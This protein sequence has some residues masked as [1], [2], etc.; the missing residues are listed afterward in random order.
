L[1]IVNKARFSELVMSA[2]QMSSEATAKRNLK[3]QPDYNRS[4]RN[5]ASSLQ[6][7]KPFIDAAV[8]AH[9]SDLTESRVRQQPELQ[10]GARCAQRHAHNQWS[11]LFDFLNGDQRSFLKQL[12]GVFAVTSGFSF[13][14]QV[15]PPS[16]LQIGI[17]NICLHW[18]S[19]TTKLSNHGFSLFGTEKE[20]E[21]QDW[22]SFL[23]ARSKELVK[24]GVIVANFLSSQD[25]AASI[26]DEIY[27]SVEALRSRGVIESEEL[28]NFN[29]PIC[30][31]SVEDVSEPSQ[32][33]RLGLEL[34]R[35]EALPQSRST[36]YEDFLQHGDLDRF[37]SE[38]STFSDAL[39]AARSEADKAAVCAELWVEHRARVARQ[40]RLFEFT[41]ELRSCRSLRQRVSPQQLQA[42][43]LVLRRLLQI[44]TVR[45]HI[46]MLKFAS[47]SE[48]MTPRLSRTLAACSLDLA[49]RKLP[50]SLAA[51]LPERLL[52]LL[53][54]ERIKALCRCSGTL[55]APTSSD[56]MWTPASRAVESAVLQ[57]K[58]AITKGPAIRSGSEVWGRPQ[59]RQCKGF[60]RCSGAGL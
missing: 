18:C 26:F 54:A 46:G 34:L 24:G 47:S 9:T 32:Y 7:F 39:N 23:Q 31:R 48:S 56:K 57:P 58:S 52:L 5:Q 13:Y 11:V 25:K 28:V 55:A 1:L 41:C 14:E 12:P 16:S 53:G 44:T 20:Q 10:L 49:W 37:V 6:R 29:C 8:A 3:M 35:A 36:Y 40:P 21:A 22:G 43:P 17:S 33:E 38:Y 50:Q 59:Q 2:Q 15:L 45:K 30:F 4:S 60:K 27:K 51:F 42:K 19:A